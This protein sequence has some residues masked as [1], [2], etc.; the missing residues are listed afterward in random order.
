[1]NE[2]KRPIHPGEILA[3]E[4]EEIDLTISQLAQ[5][6]HVSEETLFRILQR[7]A[8]IT[9]DIALKLGRFFTTGAEL[10]MN[11]QKAYELDVARENLGNKLEEI[12]PYQSVSSL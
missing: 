12:I 10:W 2:W 11:L 7:D 5:R 4:L 6:I 1:M 9:G 8:N 3:D